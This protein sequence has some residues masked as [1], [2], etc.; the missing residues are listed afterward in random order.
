MT[1]TLVTT[2][3]RAAVPAYQAAHSGAVLYD[4]SAQGRIWMRDRDSAALL[5]RLSTNQIEGLPAAPVSGRF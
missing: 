2:I 5:H 3:A 1:D 4:S